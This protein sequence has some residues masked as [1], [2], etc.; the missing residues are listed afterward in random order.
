MR[1]RGATADQ[2][3]SALSSFDAEGVIRRL[4]DLASRRG[5]LHLAGL[6][7]VGLDRVHGPGSEDLLSRIVRE[8]RSGSLLLL[9]GWIWHVG[10]SASGPLANVPPPEPAATKTEHP[11]RQ[12]VSIEWQAPEAWCSEQAGFRGTTDGYGAETLDV[13]L[14]E[15]G[16]SHSEKASV[17]V[18]GN[19]FSGR[20]MVKDILPPKA[21]S[22]L[23]SRTQIDA[24]AGGRKSPQPLGVKFVTKLAKV[25]YS[26]ERHH[27]DLSV[28]HDVVS[29]E[30][31][32]KY[33]PGW[34]AEVV[35]L[36]TKVPT[37]TGGLLDGQL[38][39]NGYRWMKTVGVKKQF[40]D[41]GAWKDL[42]KGFVLADSNHFAVGF[43][44]SGGNFTCQYGGNWP[45]KFTNWDIEA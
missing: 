6:N 22:H 1:S 3:Q 16:G 37:G 34:A 12:V 33:I 14:Q 5:L 25:A 19:S 20:W 42:P 36:A 35:K 44:E 31:D 43:Y 40:W 2:R 11:I 30:S 24:L 7:R 8:F 41:G 18:T 4:H 13:S 32:I 28:E 29:I 23:A 27:F 26:K 38:G 45:E 15:Q 39:W 9:R 10:R 17:V 21:G